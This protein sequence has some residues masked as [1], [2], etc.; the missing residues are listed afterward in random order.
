M[1][2]GLPRGL[3]ERLR[4][5]PP[6]VQS[7]ERKALPWRVASLEDEVRAAPELLLSLS[8][9]CATCVP[10]LCLPVS[11]SCVA[12]VLAPESSRP[13]PATKQE[14]ASVREPCALLVYG[15]LHGGLCEKLRRFP[16]VT[17]QVEREAE[18]QKRY[19]ELQVRRTGLVRT[20][21]PS[22]GRV[23]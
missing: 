10:L 9:S 8:V 16:Q 20:A 11:A 6:Q 21:R 12:T 7:R 22:A 15:R 17:K 4:Y 5:C 18:L 2:G 1:Y 19:A 3:R 14:L 23:D 13:C